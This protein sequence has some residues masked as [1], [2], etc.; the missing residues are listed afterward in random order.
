MSPEFL[1]RYYILKIVSNPVSFGIDNDT[2]VKLKELQNKLEDKQL[3]FKDNT[4]LKKL[5]SHNKKT[6]KR[7]LK[8]IYDEFGVEI[9]LKRNYGYYVNQGEVSEDVK[10]IF[11]RVELLLISRKSA[12]INSCISSEDSSLNTNIDTLGLIN[13][14]EKK[15][16]IHVSYSGWYDDNEFEEIEKKPFQPLYLKEKDKAWYLLANSTETNEIKTFCLDDRIK[17]IKIFKKEVENPISFDGEA[18]FKNSIGILNEGKAVEKIKIKVVNHH[19][20][21]LLV[22]PLHKSQK[23]I[24]LAKDMDLF[25]F[26]EQGGLSYENPDVWGEIEVTLKLNYELIMELL[27]YNQ[28]IKI[29]SPPSVVKDFKEHLDLIVN[30]YQ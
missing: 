22:K 10:S 23:L 28:W 2:Y 4:F 11:S 5:S 3:E 27:K 24:A 9:K 15:Y 7:D 18:Y 12:E 14:I 17:E 20:K 8:I 19:L 26:K 21:Y 6:I 16:V 30:Y 1:R 13:A 29:V 25:E